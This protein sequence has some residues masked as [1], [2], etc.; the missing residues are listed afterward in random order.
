MSEKREFPILNGKLLSDLDLNG[1]KLLGLTIPEGGGGGGGG[2]SV[3]VVA[4]SP[5]GAGKAADAAE[6]YDRLNT[7]RNLEDLSVYE[8]TNW[9]IVETDY[10]ELADFTIEEHQ[11]EFIVQYKSYI[12]AT[13]PQNSGETSL[14]L[15]GS[16]LDWDLEYDREIYI[17]IKFRVSRQK[18]VT[19]KKLVDSEEFENKLREYVP[20]SELKNYAKI[21]RVVYPFEAALSSEGVIVLEPR[22]VN[23]VDGSLPYVGVIISDMMGDDEDITWKTAGARDCVLVINC[24]VGDTAPNITWPAN[25]HPRTDAETDFACVAG[26]RNVYWITEY[27]SGEFVV[28]GWQET[29]G[30]NA[31]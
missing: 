30:G 13:I 4:P 31:Q 6:V 8:F 11:S 12:I 2:S 14:E 25:F 9:E 27:T 22:H 5:D 28:A 16:Y 3:E 1:Y 19:V 17:D 10:G 29:K 15:I 26:T 24:P 7:K 21:S 18:Q 20:L 23:I